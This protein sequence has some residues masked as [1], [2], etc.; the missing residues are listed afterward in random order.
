MNGSVADAVCAF[1]GMTIS[2]DDTRRTHVQGQTPV[3]ERFAAP[4]KLTDGQS[5]ECRW[6]NGFYLDQPEEWDDPYRF[7]GW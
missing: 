3:L 2:T 7:F 5:P 1:L 4:V 6:L